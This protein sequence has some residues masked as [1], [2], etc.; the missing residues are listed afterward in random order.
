[1]HKI[2]KLYFFRSITT[3]IYSVLRL[4]TGFV[5]AALIALKLIV[6]AAIEITSAPAKAN[7]HQP[8]SIRY[9][10]SRNHLLTK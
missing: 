3:L 10:K 4:C 7:I 6:T 5:I 9:A 8:I 1:M 2:K